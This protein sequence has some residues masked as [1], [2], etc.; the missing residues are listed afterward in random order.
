MSG[1]RGAQGRAFDFVIARGDGPAR[2]RAQVL[3]GACDPERALADLAR[4]ELSDPSALARVL[5]ICEELRALRAP[6]ARRALALLEADQAPD[7]AFA[8]PDQGLE[9]RLQ[10][11][12]ELGGILARSP[13]GRPECLDAAGDFLAGHFTPDLFQDFQWRNIA[14]YTHF[15]ANALHEAA[16]EVLQWCG[17]ELERGFRA[18]AFDPLAAARVFVLCDAHGVPGAQLEREELLLGLWTQQSP[19][20]GFGDAADPAERVEATLQGL[21][22]LIFLE[23]RVALDSGAPAR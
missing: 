6:L 12:G 11:T 15:F 22:A 2:R 14:A 3:A 10:R 8:P 1:T 17:R 18:Q 19:D 5:W 16:D 7:G 9:A 20:G 21:R 23:G 13:F 4:A